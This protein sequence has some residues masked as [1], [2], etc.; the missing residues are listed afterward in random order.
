M[1]GNMTQEQPTQTVRLDQRTLRR[2]MV[3]GLSLWVG[4]QTLLWL[5]GVTE[6]FLF[7]LLLS[8][9]LAIAMEPPVAALERRG[10]KRGGGAGLVLLG[11]F[12]TITAFLSVFG[13]L[14]FG[15][16][17][18][19][20]QALPGVIVSIVDW[21][22]S[23]FH[24][25]VSSTAITDQLSLTPDKV[26]S[27]AS[28]VAGGLMGVVSSIVGF[29]FTTLT[30]VMFA[31]YISAESHA[32]RRTVASWLRPDRQKVFITV[33]DIT[34]AKTG[35][36]VVSRVILAAISACAHVFA[37]WLIGVPYWMPLG[38]FAGVT[39]QFIPT[40]G[41]YIGI[42]VPIAFSAA[43]QPTDCLWIAA[44]ATV[45]QQIENY[46]LGPRVSRATMDLHPALAL[47]SVFIGAGVFGP[48]GA[49]IGIPLAAALLAVVDTYGKR[50][51]LVP[52]LTR[53]ET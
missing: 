38:L 49:L 24:T 53:D 13:G 40:F 10:M 1:G 48:I 27:I 28:S 3:M 7:M 20:V 50:Y 6:N 42:I 17:S 32:L 23:T 34:V 44:F 35:G 26:A 12:L 36:F 5:F 25:N 22:N 31:F 21:V 41:T 14:F 33:W 15:Q 47:A 2:A 9:L 30:I 39:S 4:L 18:S 8:W 29:I 37:F 16:L 11:M 19:A 45:Y 52:E 46:V 43:S 51:E